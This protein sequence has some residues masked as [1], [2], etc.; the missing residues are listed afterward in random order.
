MAP[1]N[2]Y[3]VDRQISEMHSMTHLVDVTSNQPDY[4]RSN[5]SV[6]MPTS[7]ENN[8]FMASMTTTD[9]VVNNVTTDI[10]SDFETVGGGLNSNPNDN[11]RVLN[12]QNMRP[13]PM[14]YQRGRKQLLLQ[15]MNEE[16]DRDNRLARGYQCVDPPHPRGTHQSQSN[17]IPNDDITMDINRTNNDYLHDNH[18]HNQNDTSLTQLTTANGG[19][20]C[21]SYVIISSDKQK[22]D[23]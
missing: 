6:T 15:A 11:Y 9:D 1:T 13:L 23:H 17:I 4:L 10:L 18:L 21:P 22:N 20:V 5:V 16:R 7:Y 3:I 8:Q 12:N 14:T 2:Q 19:W